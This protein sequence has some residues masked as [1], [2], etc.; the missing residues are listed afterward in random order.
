MKNAV[1]IAAVRAAITADPWSSVA[2]AFA[3]GACLALIEPRGTV[4]RAITSTLGALAL[5]A[6]RESAT[7]RFAAEARAWVAAR[8]PPGA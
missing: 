7:R 2:L 3:A 6:L 5:A 1:D 8:T 4:A